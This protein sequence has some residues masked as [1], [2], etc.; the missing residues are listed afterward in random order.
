MNIFALLRGHFTC[1]KLLEHKA[2]TSVG[3]TEFLTLRPWA[4]IRDPRVLG[5]GSVLSCGLGS[6]PLE[7]GR[8][9][10]QAIVFGMLECL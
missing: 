4:Q 5:A 8:N 10:D 3:K 7:A 1:A 6:Y 2:Y 9:A